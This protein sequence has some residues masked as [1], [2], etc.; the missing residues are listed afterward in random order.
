MTGPTSGANTSGMDMMATSL[1]GRDVTK[2]TNA[3]VAEG[4]R[5]S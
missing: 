4:S 2:P 5:T 3:I 1:T